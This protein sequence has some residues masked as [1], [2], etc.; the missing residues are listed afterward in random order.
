M[1][2]PLLTYTNDDFS[3]E[4]GLRQLFWFGRSDCKRNNGT[5]FC[6]R[7]DWVNVLGW[8]EKLRQY[9][10]SARGVETDSLSRTILW[11][12]LPDFESNGTMNVIEKVPTRD[13]KEIYW[14][15]D[16]YC[17][18]FKIDNDLCTLRT[19]EMDL[20][21]Y[22]PSECLLKKYDCQDLVAYVRFNIRDQ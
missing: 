21:A 7:G 4:Y 20:V 1:I 22:T 14:E 9:I 15:K 19:S 17:S 12:Y 5:F 8:E 2:L 16:P 18:G 3:S 13:G 11:M 6:E 10:V